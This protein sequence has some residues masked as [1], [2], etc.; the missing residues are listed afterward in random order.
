MTL[1]EANKIIEEIINNDNFY[2][3]DLKDELFKKY[4]KIFPGKKRGPN[5]P[6]K[7]SETDKKIWL[8]TKAFDEYVSKIEAADKTIKKISF[9]KRNLDD[10]NYPYLK[11][12]ML[13]RYQSANN[14]NR[15]DC[16]ISYPVYLFYK[17]KFD[18]I[19]SISMYYYTPQYLD[20][21][22]SMQSLWGP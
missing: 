15:F 21:Y 22:F 2:D 11:K 12:Y 14:K 20:T 4:T 7:G 18:D 3:Y 16:D 6:E 9:K 17:S 8:E 5:F 1:K 13:F 10:T 19:V